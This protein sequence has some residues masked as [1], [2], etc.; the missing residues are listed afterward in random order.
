MRPLLQQVMW[1]TPGICHVCHVKVSLLILKMIVWW[2]LIDSYMLYIHH[3]K[4][5]FETHSKHLWTTM[6]KKHVSKCW[7]RINHH[8]FIK[9][10]EHTEISIPNMSQTPQTLLKTSNHP[11]KT[12]QPSK[13][14]QKHH[15]KKTYL[16]FSPI[17]NQPFSRW[18]RRQIHLWDLETMEL[19]VSLKGHSDQVW[20]VKFS[21]NEPGAPFGEKTGQKR[22]SQ[23]GRK[24]KKNGWCEW[25]VGWHV[26]D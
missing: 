26:I 15:P 3:W 11:S 16:G 6:S 18:N 22:R 9:T 1:T 25:I 21:T 4:S 10:L 24:K 23:T 2:C 19:K 8:P 14:F 13:N 20:E 7:W 5:W 17:Q 12:H